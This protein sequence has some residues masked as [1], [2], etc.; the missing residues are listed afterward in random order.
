[1]KPNP[2]I[3]RF[4]N[5]RWYKDDNA[6]QLHRIDGPAVE[7]ITGSRHWFQNGLCHR[8]DG[9]AVELSDGSKS[10]CQDGRYHRVDGPAIEYANGDKHWYYR[11]K[12]I[13]C[14]SQQEFEK[15]IKLKAFW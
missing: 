9:P 15:I 3:D 10:W 1:M 4:G 7:L 11:G 5:K 13:S 2:E 12:Y 6:F 8:L 14:S